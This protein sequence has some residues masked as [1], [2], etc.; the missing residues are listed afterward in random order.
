[1]WFIDQLVEQQIRDAQRNG[2]FDDLPG[3]G[4]PLVLDDD[5]H[6]PPELRVAY[7]ILK[8]AGYLPAELEARREAVEIDS[9]LNTIDPADEHYADSLRRL[10]VLTLQLQQAGLSTDFLRG[11]YAQPLRDRFSHKEE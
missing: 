6:V 3:H 7:R 9:L 11:D 4:R 1:M 8:N 10:R 2:E 5:S